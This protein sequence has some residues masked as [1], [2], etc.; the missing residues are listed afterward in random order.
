MKKADAA[1]TV[2]L[3]LLSRHLPLLAVSIRTSA[4]AAASLEIL[5][6][7]SL[8]CP[9]RSNGGNVKLITN[10]APPSSILLKRPA[11]YI[12]VRRPFNSLSRPMTS[13][14][15]SNQSRPRCPFQAGGRPRLLPLTPFKEPLQ[16]KRRRRGRAT[17]TKGPYG[18]PSPLK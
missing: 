9:T 15:T 13:E 5:P 10:R 1:G 14:T 8:Q 7:L 11:V 4:A 12:P 3:R 18:S 6:A 17:V 16:R 2:F